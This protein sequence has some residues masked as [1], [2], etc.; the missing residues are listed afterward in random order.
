[1][2]TVASCLDT[3]T[4]PPCKCPLNLVAGRVVPN[5]VQHL[6]AQQSQHLGSTLEWLSVVQDYL[7]RESLLET[8]H[9]KH[10]RNPVQIYVNGPNNTTI[11]EIY[12][13]LA[14]IMATR[15][16]DVQW[17]CKIESCEREGW[18]FIHVKL[19]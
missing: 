9:F 15:I 14:G 6:V 2:S 4:H 17:T 5:I 19:R 1:M 10:F 8:N 13:H 3:H 7:L 16:S 12:P 18:L 11:E